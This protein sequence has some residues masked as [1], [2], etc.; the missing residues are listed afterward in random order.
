MSR[1]RT[2]AV[3]AGIMLAVLLSSLDQTIVGTAMPRIIAELGGLNM[4]TWVATAYMLT[5]TT[6]L[7][8]FG[9]LSDMYGR[10]WFYIGGVSLFMVSSALCGLSQNMTM[11]VICRGLQGLA[12]GM[13][14][15]NAMA[16]IGDIFPPSERGKYQG[17]LMSMFGIASIVGPTAG[18]WLTDNLSWQWVF[19]VNLPIGAFAVL[20]LFV[21]LPKYAE[22]LVKRQVDYL[23]ATALILAVV[24][25]LLALVW[26]GQDYPWA[27]AQI[28]GLLIFS[29]VMLIAFVF[30]EEKAAEPIIP[31]HVFK[32]S[33]FAISAA[34]GF[35][36][37]IGMFGAIMFLPLYIQAV[38]GNTAT[39]SG[40]VLTPMMLTVVI[41]SIIAGQLVSRT[42]R[43]RLLAI[44]GSAI[45]SLGIWF[46]STMNV[47]TTN[48]EVV[49]NMVI[50]GIGLGLTMPIF[51]IAVQNAFPQNMLGVV[52]S[53]LQ[54]FRGI[55][56]AV[57]MAVMGTILANIMIDQMTRKI[58]P[59]LAEMMPAGLNSGLGE[60]QALLDPDN[61]AKLQ[62]V[63]DKLGP[64]GQDLLNQ[65]TI[66]VRES[67]ANAIQHVFFIG[68]ILVVAST[69]LVLFLK[70]LPLR[71]TKHLPEDKGAKEMETSRAHGQD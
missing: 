63:F 30:I 67:M 25:L 39:N 28:I 36:L 37:S 18:G 32:N 70:E 8:I 60:L 65:F 61:M 49:R 16:I 33:I 66:A 51:I 52:S 71:K 1:K 22:S 5:S 41:S 20:V 3:L 19:Y 26:G 31:L 12:G 29:G 17:L 15:A 44:G 10:R 48:E 47:S 4:Y 6:G 50:A 38:Q 54:F 34:S 27:S 46:F 42:G 56:G 57:G 55:G 7:P 45:V 68:F 24:P 59:A 11:L 58:P 35:F 69:I 53:G 40:I 64:N 62:A 23:G 2:I 9:K 13:M 21:A 43:Y 14:M